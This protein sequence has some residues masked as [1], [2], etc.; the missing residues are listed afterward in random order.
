M[1][2]TRIAGDVIM[3]VLPFAC[4]WHYRRTRFPRTQ[5]DFISLPAGL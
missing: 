4:T 5:N 1:T 2:L 3:L